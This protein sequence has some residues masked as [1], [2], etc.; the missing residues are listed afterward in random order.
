[1]RRLTIT[2][3]PHVHRAG[4]TSSAIDLDGAGDWYL[5]EICPCHAY[6]RVGARMWRGSR[7][8]KVPA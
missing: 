8:R 6:R 2:L 4:T 7:F 5:I 3:V 1:M